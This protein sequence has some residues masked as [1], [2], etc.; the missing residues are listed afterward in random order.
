MTRK[1]FLALAL[2]LFSLNVVSAQEQTF[3]A[4]QGHSF[5]SKGEFQERF[6]LSFEVPSVLRSILPS[7]GVVLTAYNAD[8]S[9]FG[10]H[11]WYGQTKKMITEFSKD[12]LKVVLNANPSLKGAAT[13]NLAM[14]E[15][16]EEPATL[17]ECVAAANDTCGR[18][19]VTGVT[20]GADGSCSFTCSVT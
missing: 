7:A 10:K 18:G 6:Q 14:E 12:K 1:L 11:V 8:G 2:V 5:R 15:S 20:S 16:A 17:R 3:L 9:I 19:K 13:Y 4:S